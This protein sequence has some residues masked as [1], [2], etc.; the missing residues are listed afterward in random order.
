[1]KIYEKFDELAKYMKYMTSGRPGQ[2]WN[3]K[4]KTFVLRKKITTFYFNI[5]SKIRNE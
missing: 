1:M 3:K 2:S 5:K 4:I